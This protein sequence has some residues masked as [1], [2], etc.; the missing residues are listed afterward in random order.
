M[1]NLRSVLLSEWQQESLTLA[2]RPVVTLS[3]GQMQVAE[4]LYQIA[5]QAERMTDCHYF[6]WQ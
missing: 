3:E 4:N 1:D 5:Q 2:D 6:H